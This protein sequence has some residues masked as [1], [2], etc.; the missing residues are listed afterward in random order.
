MEHYIKSYFTKSVLSNVQT[1]NTGQRSY[2]DGTLHVNLSSS[3]ELSQCLLVRIF[4]TTTQP[5]CLIRKST[6][7]E[8]W[9]LLMRQV[10]P[11][12]FA[13]W[14]LAPAPTKALMMA[15]WLQCTISWL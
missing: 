9:T 5:T 2:Q 10:P 15:R 6:S 8:L 13:R 7:S 11:K 3:Q 1:V 12:W 4:S 14:M